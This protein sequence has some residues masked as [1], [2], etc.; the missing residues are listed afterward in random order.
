MASSAFYVMKD[1]ERVK[2]GAKDK[3]SR[4]R[5]VSKNRFVE[6][7]GD[8]LKGALRMAAYE[9]TGLPQPDSPSDAATKRYV[10]EKL[11]ALANESD[12]SWSLSDVLA[13]GNVADRAIAFVG[14]ILLGEGT[15]ASDTGIAVGRNASATGNHSVALGTGSEAL[16]ENSVAIGRNA[17]VN[18][19]GTLRVGSSSREMSLEVTGNLSVSGEIEGLER[20]TDTV[21]ADSNGT[22]VEL[23]SGFEA[24]YTVSATPVGSLAR[25]GVFNRSSSGFTVKSSKS[26][27]V[28]LV[29]VP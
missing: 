1:G 21:R 11:A 23:P 5:G 17:S 24:N 16:A 9:I 29:V 7:T 18:E 25:V 20:W 13:D 15:A 19:S 28:D 12:V 4:D 26:T 14:G 22:R 6:I 27:E 10:D 8:T 3:S 2:L